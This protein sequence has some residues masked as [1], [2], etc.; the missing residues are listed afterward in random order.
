M[1][2]KLEQCKRYEI[3]N[4]KPEVKLFTPCLIP[5]IGFQKSATNKDVEWFANKMAQH[6]YGNHMRFFVAGNWEPKLRLSKPYERRFKK[7]R[8]TKINQRHFDRLWKRI[9]YFVERGIYP[10][11]T[12][13]DGCSLHEGRPGFWNTHWMNGKRN[14]NN[15]HDRWF[16]ITHCEE[17]LEDP[18]HRASYDIQNEMHEYVLSEAKRHFG[19]HFLI[20]IGNELDARTNYHRR[21]RILC[22]DILGHG[23]KRRIFTS[24][25]RE[26][27]FFYARPNSNVQ[28]YCIRILHNV[29]DYQDYLERKYIFGGSGTHMVSQD[30]QMPMTTKQQTKNNVLQILRSESKGYEGNLRP[31]LELKEG[32]WEN[33]GYNADWTFRSMEFELMKA[34]G[35]AFESYVSGE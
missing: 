3:R 32:Y 9:G 23:L 20:E 24:M 31:L 21:L 10:M 29:R 22:E 18:R 25:L 8:L 35:K 11:I 28:E 16:S 14:V 12:L 1:K 26:N 15:T 5:S 34:Y 30:G 13:T 6:G 2:H 17:H 27:T 33:V 7:Y 19:T 4:N